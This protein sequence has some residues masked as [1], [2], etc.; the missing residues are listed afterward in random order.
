MKKAP[1]G[2]IKQSFE[3]KYFIQK[4]WELQRLESINGR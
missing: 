1:T 3:E 2:M 4:R